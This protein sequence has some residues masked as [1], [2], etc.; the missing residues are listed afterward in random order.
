MVQTMPSSPASD[1]SSMM[2]VMP[3][4]SASDI[5]SM[6]HMMP[7]PSASDM[8]S[9]VHM[10]PSP[11]AS[12][13]SSMM[14]MM[15]SPSASEMALTVTSIIPTVAPTCPSGFTGNDCS[16]D[17]DDCEYE[18]CSGNGDCL[19]RINGFI[20]ECKNNYFGKNCEKKL[21]ACNPNPCENDGT[22]REVGETFKCTCTSAFEGTTCQSETPTQTFTGTV[23]LDQDYKEDY[24]DIN[25]PRS[26]VLITVLDSKLKPFFKKK[27]PDFIVI[28]Y[29][30]FF[31]GSVG[32]DYELLFPTTSNVTNGNIVQALREG[33]GSSE[34][35]FLRL[36]GDITVTKQVVQ[37]TAAPTATKEK[38]TIKDWEI[39]LIAAATIV[40]FLLVAIGVLAVKYRNAVQGEKKELYALN[41]EWEVMENGH[42]GLRAQSGYK[43][44]NGP[45]SYVSPMYGQ[46]PGSD[47][48]AYQHDSA[49]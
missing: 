45:Q 14:H 44:R 48:K 37:K 22:C 5:S 17:I 29:K 26:R 7:S 36:T 43:S 33:N 16:K 8:S 34:L 47:N 31:K 38:S 27:F 21:S 2:R 19:D 23:K 42:N 15:P 4:P 46:I 20:C 18:N 1:M 28:N 10:M 12:D 25:S 3:S 11:S 13:M 24:D 41:G 40:F 32:V 30:R 49:L 9:M 39:V 35:G 6:M